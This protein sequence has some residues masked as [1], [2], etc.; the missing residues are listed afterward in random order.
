DDYLQSVLP[1]AVWQAHHRGPAERCLVV[2]LSRNGLGSQPTLGYGKAACA[3]CGGSPN[4]SGT[5]VHTQPLNSSNREGRA[6]SEAVS[7]QAGGYLRAECRGA[8]RTAHRRVLSC[9]PG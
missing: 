5:T 9:R 1:S 6:V 2:Q 4:R 3:R 8:L 7:A